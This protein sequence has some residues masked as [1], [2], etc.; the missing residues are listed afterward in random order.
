MWWDFLYFSEASWEYDYQHGY[1]LFPACAK[2]HD[3]LLSVMSKILTLEH[4]A[5][6]ESALH[7]LGHWQKSHPVQVVAIVDYF[8]NGNPGLRPE[9]KTYALKARAGQVL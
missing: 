7:G 5:C 4:D 6:R 8:L 9:L 1:Q 3:D 2:V